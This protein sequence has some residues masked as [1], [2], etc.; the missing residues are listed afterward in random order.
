[1]LVTGASGFIGRQTIAPLLRRGFEV[2]SIGRRA[3]PGTTHHAADLLDPPATREIVA[4][5][6]ASHLLHLAWYVEPGAYWRSPHNLD[7]V[8]AS[9]G[10]ARAFV[11]AGGRRIVAAGTCA[12]YAWGDPVLDEAATPCTPGTLYGACKDALRRVLTPF[13]DAAGVSIAWGRIFF[14]YGPGEAP[15]RLV[16]DAI[17]LLSNGGPFETSHGRQRRDFMHVADVAAAFAALLDSDVRGA[18]NIAS[19]NAPPVRTVLEEVARHTGGLDRIDFGARILS[20]SEPE[21]IKA[22]VDR[23]RHEVGYIPTYDLATGI[24][25]AVRAACSDN[26][27]RSAS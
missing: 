15:G 21:I 18:V 9:L 19:G 8:A 25:D 22:A 17:R 7:W 6:G 20:S 13:G 10:L 11:E 12:E 24:A 2:H 16:S 27:A 14:L 3:V 5:L 4:G 23:L 26:R 1:M